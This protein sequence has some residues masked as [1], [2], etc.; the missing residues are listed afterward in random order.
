V[1]RCDVLVVGGGPAGSTCA[2]RLV[3][4]GLDVVVLDAKTFPR[5]K[6][7]AGWI[8]PQIVAELGLDLD[9]YAKERVLQPFLGFEVSL[10]GGPAARV[11]SREPISWG[12]RRCEFDAWLLERCGA[13]LR[14]GEPL[15]ALARDG[16]E[17][18][19]NA[20]LRARVVVGAGGHFCPVA[21]ALAP[22][23]GPPEPVI[24]AQEIEFA[25]DE[26]QARRCPVSAEVPELYFERDLR[27]YAWLVRKGP[28]LN[29]GIGRQDPHDL[30]GHAQAFLARAGALGR[31]PPRLPPKRHG[32]AYLLYGQSP[33]PLAGDG[34]VLVGDAAGFA[35][36]QS[37][38]GIRPAVESALLAADA[39]ARGDLPGYARAI[40]ARFGPRAGGGL[41]LSRLVP[42]RV[43]P[44]LAEK[45]LANERFARRVVVERWFLHRNQPPLPGLSSAPRGA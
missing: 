44:W 40:E 2:A 18:V 35:W 33:R 38:E 3:R 36:P 8:T 12:I 14:L 27:G 23:S 39:I 30:A 20:E 22:Q 25:L 13:R 11:T 7:C 16:G 29:V 42:E 4:A 41:T 15:R 10:L 21:R 28:V 34:F 31:L 5:D 9:A 1:E 43:R 6:V 45:L 24:A 19:A 32:H 17:W 26:E 37:G